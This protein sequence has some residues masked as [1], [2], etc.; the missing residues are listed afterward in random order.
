MHLSGRHVE[1]S[2]KKNRKKREGAARRNNTSIRE[3]ERERE[4]MA[5]PSVSVEPWLKT[6]KRELRVT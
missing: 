4:T 2:K 1:R 6:I 5:P 3:R